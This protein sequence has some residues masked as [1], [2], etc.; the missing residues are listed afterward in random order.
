MGFSM[1]GS[2][3]YGINSSIFESF[4]LPFDQNTGKLSNTPRTAFSG[5]IFDVSWLPD[6]ESLICRKYSDDWILKLLIYN[7]KSGESKI[8]ANN[9]DIKGE[10]KISPDSKSVL[11]F[12]YDKLRSEDINYNGGLY[13]I[14]IKTGLPA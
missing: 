3:Y 14:D 12:G 1:D 6:G 7:S 5:P 4:T 2:L 9:L 10:P 13:S 11:A 8:L